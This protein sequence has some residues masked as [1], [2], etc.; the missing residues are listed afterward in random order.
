[1]SKKLTEISPDL[2][3]PG[4]DVKVH[5]PH[6]CQVKS[7][8]GWYE[9]S[10]EIDESCEYPLTISGNIVSKPWSFRLGAWKGGSEYTTDADDVI[11]LVA[12]LLKLMDK[13]SSEGFSA[14]I[15]GEWLVLSHPSKPDYKLRMALADAR[16]IVPLKNTSLYTEVEYCGP[17]YDEEANR[18]CKLDWSIENS[19]LVVTNKDFEELAQELKARVLSLGEGKDPRIAQWVSEEIE[20]ELHLQGFSFSPKSEKGIVDF[21]HPVGLSGT[22]SFAPFTVGYKYNF[23]SKYP[24]LQFPTDEEKRKVVLFT[25]VRHKYREPYT[26]GFLAEEPEE[27]IHE[28]R[29]LLALRLVYQEVSHAWKSDLLV[30]KL[31]E[32]RM[33]LVNPELAGNESII[34]EL[35]Q[36]NSKFVLKG[37]GE[38]LSYPILDTPTVVDTEAITRA[39]VERAEEYVQARQVRRTP[40]LVYKELTKVWK[41]DILV[42]M[43]RDNTLKL[44]NTEL[45][46]DDSIILELTVEKD[47]V[48]LKGKGESYEIS[49]KPEE[50][51]QTIV[52][53]AE[54]HVQ[55]FIQETGY[56]QPTTIV[57]EV[58]E[59]D[60]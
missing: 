11:T 29:R 58:P 13:L 3:I 50:I 32:S 20:K 41:S 42:P 2:T 45:D 1:M 37:M 46:G 4:F 51:A 22:L 28:F 24:N 16:K 31:R 52:G 43:L 35:T 8:D 54:K 57:R 40:E 15:K 21:F 60:F 39:I 18:K 44:V 30:P 26:K 9:F 56:I 48:K 34:L 10:V 33:L 5:S 17:A 7:K 12:N 23:N 59:L 47:E 38:E 55:E 36:E 49:S 6:S 27:V 19:R 25:L 53:L 14:K